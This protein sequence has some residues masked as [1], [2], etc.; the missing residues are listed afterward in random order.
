MP[1]CLIIGA[2]FS[3]LSAA[4]KLSEKGFNIKI[5]EASPKPG[6]RAYSFVD[7]ETGSTIDNGQHILM[8][9]YRYTLDFLKIIKASNKILIQ[10]KLKVVFVK[11]GFKIFNLESAFGFYPINLAIGILLYK[12]LTFSERISVIKLFIKLF[13][14]NSNNISE[15]S[16]RKWLENEGQN[17][18]TQKCLW[19]IIAVGA[20]NTN[21]ESASAKIFADILKEIFL[22]GNFNTKIIIPAEGLTEMY[23]NQAIDFIKTRNGEINFSEEVLGFNIKN[24]NIISVKTDKNIYENF[25]YVISTIPPFALERIS[26][27]SVN[28]LSVKYSSILTVHIWLKENNLKEKF[29]GFIDSTIHWVF[30]HKE[31]ITIVV[32][33]A[34]KLIEKS[35]E[36]L[37]EITIKELDEYLS[38]K[39]ENISTYKIIKEK[40]AT[41]V[42]SKEF[43]NIRPTHETKIKNLILA[44]DWVQTGLP[45]TIESAV[46]SGYMAAEKVVFKVS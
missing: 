9:C 19:E 27:E 43:L 45:S 11:E 35:K 1:S 18:N 37:F 39:K 8:G 7:K 46:K 29:Y 3:G 42:P 26:T 22:R 28:N 25:D 13:F 40:R 36:E 21:L 4:V 34:D 16:V 24:D 14:I 17:E 38:I 41:F 44:G 30:N 33:D 15:L 20:L 23:C 10:D 2:G 32:S 5:L 31:H 12:A 6:G